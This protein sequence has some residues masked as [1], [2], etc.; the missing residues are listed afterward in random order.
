MCIIVSI[1]ILAAL[2]NSENLLFP[3]VYTIIIPVVVILMYLHI[4]MEILPVPNQ[5][6]CHSLVSAAG[7][8]ILWDINKK[9][10]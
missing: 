3:Q 2:F 5:F 8:A 10:C 9:G 6:T 4:L 7:L 1:L